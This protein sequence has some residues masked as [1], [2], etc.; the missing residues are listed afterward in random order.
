MPHLFQNIVYIPV[1]LETV[2]LN[3]HLETYAT[4]DHNLDSRLR[5]ELQVCC[6]LVSHKPLTDTGQPHGFPAGGAY[7]SYS[8]TFYEFIKEHPTLMDCDV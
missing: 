5:L 7:A 2:K 6:N 8:K 1:L 4:L 3:I